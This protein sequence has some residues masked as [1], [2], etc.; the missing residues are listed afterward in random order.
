MKQPDC[1]LTIVFPKALEENIIDHLL[2]H[3]E[4]ASGFTT[5][6]VEGHGQGMVYRSVNEQVR[7]RARRMKMEVVMERQ[8]AQALVAH[9]K[10]SMPSREIAYWISPIDEFGRFA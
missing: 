1:C 2:E 10:E 6:E 8:D 3:P 5:Y 4:V 7:G 9:F